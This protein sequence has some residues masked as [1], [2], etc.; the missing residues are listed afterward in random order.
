M[1]IKSIRIHKLL[2]IFLQL[3]KILPHIFIFDACKSFFV[4]KISLDLHKKIIFVMNLNYHYLFFFCPRGWDW[5]LHMLSFIGLWQL[6][7]RHCSRFHDSIFSMT[8]LHF[9][10]FQF[11]FKKFWK[12]KLIFLRRFLKLYNKLTICHR[13]NAVDI[14]MDSATSRL[15]GPQ[16]APLDVCIKAGFSPIKKNFHFS[17]NARF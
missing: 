1:Q 5:W 2:E 11:T 14:S 12:W 3:W 6:T 10:Y 8:L 4:M 13:S 9:Y 7:W 17:I 16:L 15:I